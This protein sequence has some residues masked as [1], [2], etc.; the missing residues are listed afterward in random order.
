MFVYRYSEKQPGWQYLVVRRTNRD[1]QQRRGRVQ[2]DVNDETRR[3]PVNHRTKRL[4]QIVLVPSAEWTMA[5]LRRHPHQATQLLY[6]LHTTKVNKSTYLRFL[7]VWCSY[8]ILYYAWARAV[9]DV[10]ALPEYKISDVSIFWGG[11]WFENISNMFF[12]ISWV[13][14]HEGITVK[15]CQS[16]GK[17]PGLFVT[18][19]YSQILYA[20]HILATLRRICKWCLKYRSSA[21]KRYRLNAR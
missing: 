19:K 4:R 15:A 5:R 9:K 2:S 18:I 13:L 11:G 1:A 20:A 3:T 21:S 17:S 14:R 12:Y 8:Y 10:L 16:L 7:F 6:V